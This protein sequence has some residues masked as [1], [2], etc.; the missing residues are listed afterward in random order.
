MKVYLLLALFG[1]V[2]LLVTTVLGLA[3]IMLP[4]KYPLVGGLFLVGGGLMTAL[5][6]R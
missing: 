4:A 2:I 5:V 6:S 1:F 3:G